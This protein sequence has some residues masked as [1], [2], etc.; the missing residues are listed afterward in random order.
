MSEVTET[1]NIQDIDETATSQTTQ[2]EMIE[3]SKV[4]DIVQSRIARAEKKVRDEY[5]DVDV[6]LYNQLVQEKQTAKQL[7][8]KEQGK[9]DELLSDTVKPLQHQISALKEQIRVE[10]VD[11]SILGSASNMNAINPEQVV[12]LLQNQVK[13]NDGDIEVIDLN[14]G[15]QRYNTDAKKY[16]VNELVNEF[17]TNNP[18]FVKASVAGSGTSSNTESSGIEKT[19]WTTADMS[20]PV[21]RQQYKNYKR[22]A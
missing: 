8:L 7:M 11:K 6:D 17:L 15:N 13:F 5:N 9:F 20:D 16:S 1:E 4:N 22:N 21:V 14:T 2:V 10:K 19:D 18:H 3:K 12:Q